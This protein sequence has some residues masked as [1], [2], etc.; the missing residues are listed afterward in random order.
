MFAG[1]TKIQQ[2]TAKQFLAKSDTELYTY[3]ITHI[4]SPN[5]KAK[6]E[7][8]KRICFGYWK[9]GLIHDANAKEVNL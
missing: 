7:R 3:Y 4:A 9:N 6:T 1:T 2:D 8:G 5:V